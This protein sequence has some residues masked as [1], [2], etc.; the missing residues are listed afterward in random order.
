M[1]CG[2]LHRWLVV[3]LAAATLLYGGT[4][5]LA[6]EAATAPAAQ[7]P[8][9]QAPVPLSPAPAPKVI[10]ASAPVA[11]PAPAPAFAPAPTPAAPASKPAG[12]ETTEVPHIALLLPLG[13]PAFARH[14]EAVRN[15]FLAAAKLDRGRGLPVRVYSAG[16]DAQ[17]TVETYIK[18]LGAGARVVVGPL[19]RTGVTAL[20]ESAA[21]LVPTLTLN[22][23]EG[24]AAV[25]PE[26]Y[27]LNLQIEAEA[28]Q[29]AQ[30]AWQDGRRVAL[31]I[32]GDTPLLKRIHQAFV[33]EFTRLGGSV[34]SEHAYTTN[35]ASLARIK[36]AANAA[37]VDMAF[38]ALDVARARLMRPYLGA[39]ALY[40]TS[41]VYPGNAGPLA[42][43]DL[44]G[45]RFLDMPWLLQPDHAAVMAYPRPNYREAIEFERFYALGIDAFRIAQALLSGT[46]DAALDGVTGRLTLG[47]DRSFSRG[48]TAAQFVDGK[49]TVRSAP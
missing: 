17:Q 10:P 32:N 27:T 48:L 21:V 28:R 47:S 1:R 42:G 5:A 9:L 18:A 14:A 33:E 46:A 19:T 31:T 30:L 37:G 45:V 36:Q 25:A 29:V 20:A 38:M 24:R 26:I 23:P 2:V 7:P 35:Q 34:A 49:L 15:G 3:P 39:L 6:S 43:F 8:A 11:V 4:C 16:D 40:A 41:Q 13:S 12:I 22:V 44:T